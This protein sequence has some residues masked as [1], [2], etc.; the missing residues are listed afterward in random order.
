MK[1]TFYDIMLFRKNQGKRNYFQVM[2]GI[3]YYAAAFLLGWQ[4]YFHYYV[5]N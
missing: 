1:K 3:L 5:L 4:L 2:L